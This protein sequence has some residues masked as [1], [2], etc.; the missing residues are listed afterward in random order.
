MN[1]NFYEKKVAKYVCIFNLKCDKMIF[2]GV[3]ERPLFVS[4]LSSYNQSVTNFAHIH[5]LFDDF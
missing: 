2:W 1:T 5:S 3:K 4:I